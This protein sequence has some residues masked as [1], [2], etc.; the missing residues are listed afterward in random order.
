MPF[1]ILCHVTPS[2]FVASH[3]PRL[4]F[5]PSPFMRVAL[6][7]CPG[8]FHVVLPPRYGLNFVPSHRILLPRRTT[9]FLSCRATSFFRVGPPP[10]AASHYPCLSHRTTFFFVALHHLCL[11]SRIT[12][13][14]CCTIIVCRVA[15]PSSSPGHHLSR[16]STPVSRVAPPPLFVASAPPNVAPHLSRILSHRSTPACRVARP[17]SQHP[18]PAFHDTA[19]YHPRLS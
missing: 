15:S 14:S 18:G 4:S 11:L 10:F 17:S 2:L 12:P 5:A 1:H 16:H 7:H 3:H 9:P 6:R 19:A 8:F 13:L